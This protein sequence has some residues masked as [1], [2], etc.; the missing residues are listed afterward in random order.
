[1]NWQIPEFVCHFTKH[2]V[3]RRS[4]A[5]IIF[6]KN[7]QDAKPR[8]FFLTLTKIAFLLANDAGRDD[9][10]ESCA[11]LRNPSP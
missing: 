4:L 5:I 9:I 3:R 1:M 11:R 6:E 7:T 10:D 2:N 8:W